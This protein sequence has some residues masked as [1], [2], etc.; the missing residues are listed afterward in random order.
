MRGRVLMK[1]FVPFGWI[2][3]MFTVSSPGIFAQP[4]SG[5]GRA[6]V[7][8]SLVKLRPGETQQFKAIMEPQ[9]LRAAGLAHNVK[10]SVDNI[11]GG[12]KELGTIDTN[13]LYRAPAKTPKPCEIHICAEVEEAANRFLWATVLLATP[14]YELLQ[15][16]GKNDETERYLKTPQSIALTPEGDLLIADIGVSKIYRF[17]IDG[18]YLGEIGLGGGDGPG[19]I[20]PPRDI[21]VDPKGRVVVSDLRTGPPRIQI[22]N[23]DGSF[24]CG[25]GQ[26]GVW[27]GHVLRTQGMAFDPSGRLLVT[28]IDNMRVN[29]YDG[30][31]NFLESWEKRGVNPGNFNAPYGLVIDRNGDVFVPGYYGPC[32]KFTRDGVFL[33]AFAHADPPDGPVGFQNSAGDRWGNIYLAVRSEGISPGDF[34]E[35]KGK[36]VAILKYNN[37]GD[38]ITR[39]DLPPGELGDTD[40]VVD[41]GGDLYIVFDRKDQKGIEIYIEN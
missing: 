35:D 41:K 24:L 40:M 27:E 19:H 20:S 30:E 9:Y 17:S 28:D 38:F 8:P 36:Q 15:N 32:Q 3:V 11:P 6:F 33:F 1:C 37:N 25:F 39:F 2:L 10:W 14:S 4:D 31:G 21:A 22:F 23:P 13:G 7:R 34:D 12:N 26:K 16:W 18:E 5:P 29:I